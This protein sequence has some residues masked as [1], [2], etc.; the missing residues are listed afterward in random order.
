MQKKIKVG[1]DEAGTGALFGPIVVAAT[2][3]PDGWYNEAIADSKKLTGR[4]R[5]VLSAE[6]RQNMK[7][8]IVVIQPD[9][10]VHKNQNTVI[11]EAY[12]KIIKSVSKKYPGSIL[13]IDG[14]KLLGIKTTSEIDTRFIPK[15]DATEF[16]V[17]A[18]S[19]VA[20]HHRDQIII[21]NYGKGTPYEDWGLD[22]NKGYGTKNHIQRILEYGISDKHRVKACATATKG[23]L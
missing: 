13:T 11:A 1:A 23:K 4:S 5:E 7:F 16:E 12:N 20:K 17:S 8:M 9:A 19:I 10:L 15:A 21:K 2:C 14:L 22:K 6:I 3:N 18:A